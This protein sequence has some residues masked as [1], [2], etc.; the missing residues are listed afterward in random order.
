MLN[1]HISHRSRRIHRTSP[2]L[3]GDY[4]DLKNI[5]QKAGVE[6]HLCLKPYI[7]SYLQ[8]R[9]HTQHRLSTFLCSNR[10]NC[11]DI[12]AHTQFMAGRRQ[13]YHETY[14]ERSISINI[15]SAD[16][17]SARLVLFRH[18]PSIF[19]PHESDCLAADYTDNSCCSTYHYPLLHGDMSGHTDSWNRNDGQC[20]LQYADHHL[21]HVKLISLSAVL[22][23][24]RPRTPLHYRR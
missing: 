8:T 6:I 24:S 11:M 9:G 18:I 16:N 3:R 14:L 4:R 7:A 17:N 1:L 21:G 20:T 22:R 23:M 19:H 5:A 10:R 2:D 12:S 15:M 13:R